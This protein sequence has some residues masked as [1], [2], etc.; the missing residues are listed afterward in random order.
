MPL[1]YPIGKARFYHSTNTNTADARA[2]LNGVDL[3]AVGLVPWAHEDPADGERPA[4]LVYDVHRLD[5][6]L[7][8]AL[9]IIGRPGPVACVGPLRDEIVIS[10]VSQYHFLFVFCVLYS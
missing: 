6:L 7:A 8:V 1:C 3:A 9:V 5:H 2:D 4:L 10:E